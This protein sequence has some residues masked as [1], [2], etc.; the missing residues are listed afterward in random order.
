MIG[1]RGVPLLSKFGIELT[2]VSKAQEGFYFSRLHPEAVQLLAAVDGQGEVLVN[3]KWEKMGPEQAYLTQPGAP[4][5]YRATAECPWT[6]C[7]AIYNPASLRDTGCLLPSAPVVLPT[8]ARQLWHAI[9]GTCD[10]TTQPDGTTDLWVRLIH[11]TVLHALNAHENAP[12]LAALWSVVNA[13]LSREWTLDDLARIAAM[14]KEN[15][16]RVCLRELGVSPMRQLTRLRV[17]RATELISCSS[18]KLASIA[19]RV[20]YGDPFAFSAAFKRETGARPS[21]YRR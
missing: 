19:E 6:V 9:E 4:H 18:D 10:A 20:G 12:R 21:A 2:G 13:D 8:P 14:S 7:W 3:G 1:V 5:A 17:N 16:R 11:Q 15:L